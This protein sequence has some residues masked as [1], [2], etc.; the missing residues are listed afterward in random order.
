MELIIKV[1]VISMITA[2]IVLL[3]KKNSP[4]I[5]LLIVV[6]ACATILSAAFFI[7]KD[8][9]ELI[10]DITITAEIEPAAVSTVIKSV[11]IGIVSK[12]ASDVCKDA[13][14]TAA[15]SSVELFGSVAVVYIAL[16]LIK[17]VLKNINSL[18]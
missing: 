2:I 4:E 17:T 12:F 8:I 14:Q 9:V 16:P 18:I 6:A 7:L 1:F 5:S 13:G 10:K 11:G 15:A 3:L